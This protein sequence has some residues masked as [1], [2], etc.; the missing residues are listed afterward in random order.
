MPRQL[1]FPTE[2]L[3]AELAEVE[4]IKYVEL[5]WKR[6][7]V[8]KEQTSNEAQTGGGE[9]ILSGT[10]KKWQVTK[11][12]THQTSISYLPSI[13]EVMFF[14]IVIF[15]SPS[16]ICSTNGD[17]MSCSAQSTAFLALTYI[18]AG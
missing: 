11:P 12:S 13:M 15:L 9:G 10:K 4:L 7:I 16:W 3:E 8:P 6:C 17:H 14:G 2:E 5:R 1:L 18:T